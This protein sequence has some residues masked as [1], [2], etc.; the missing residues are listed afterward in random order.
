[1]KFVDHD[2]FGSTHGDDEHQVLAELPAKL[3]A[4]KVDAVVSGMGC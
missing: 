4:M 3:K 2:E 1:M